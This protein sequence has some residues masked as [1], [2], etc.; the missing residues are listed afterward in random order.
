MEP[1]TT[2]A[3]IAGIVTYLGTQLAKNKPISAFISEF[4]GATIDWIRPIFLKDDGTPQKS[5]K[6]LEEDPA[7]E[8][9]QELVQAVLKAELVDEPE[10]EKYI[11]EMF[12]K[13]SQTKEGAQVINNIINSKNVVTGNISAGGDVRVGDTG[14]TE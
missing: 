13:I 3:M 5:L 8:T 9:K 14:K 4:S 6:K 7:N 2:S 1:I 12:E 10:A 11:L